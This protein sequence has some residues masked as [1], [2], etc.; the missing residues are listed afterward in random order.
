MR[1][2]QEGGRSRI[3][4]TAG[5]TAGTAIHVGLGDWVERWAWTAAS[6]VGVEVAG[7]KV[8]RGDKALLLVCLVMEVVGVALQ[9]SVRVKLALYGR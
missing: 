9:R 2:T 7:C 6:A 1:C 5:I 3:D 8:V 4:F